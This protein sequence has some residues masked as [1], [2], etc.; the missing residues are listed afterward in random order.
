MEYDIDVHTEGTWSFRGEGLRYR[1]GYGVASGQDGEGGDMHV[2]PADATAFAAPKF[3]LRELGPARLV[4]SSP[5]A[6]D[7][8]IRWI[9][10]SAPCF[11][12]CVTA[13]YRSRLHASTTGWRCPP[14]AIR[15]TWKPRSDGAPRCAV[16]LRRAAV[17]PGSL[18]RNLDCGG[19]QNCQCQPD[20]TERSSASDAR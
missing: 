1:S 14:A 6:A 17:F 4:V 18:A 5:G 7:S 9:A 16:R 11:A 13:S 19:P 3:G 10:T 15:S 2:H 8:A 20:K 12:T